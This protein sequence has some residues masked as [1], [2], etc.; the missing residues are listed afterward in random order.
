MIQ[1]RGL[2]GSV[3]K[4]DTEQRGVQLQTVSAQKK[5]AFEFLHF[6]QPFS[7]T[8]AKNLPTISALADGAKGLQINW[9]NGDREIVL[10]NGNGAR[11]ASDSKRLI[12]REDSKGN[13]KRLIF[14]LSS[15]AKLD[16]KILFH[17]SKPVS[18]SFQI[19]ESGL[20]R[21]KAENS[22][23]TEIKLV[24]PISPKSIKVN[25]KAVNFKFEQTSKTL[26]FKLPAGKNLIDSE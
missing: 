19:T 1:A 26:S 14:Q 25:G 18:G 8:E 6:L 4:G 2:P 15:E 21:G 5:T 23:S 3:A 17:S 10:L 20:L 9:S 16:G 24:I 7:L 22:E 11:I 13:W 12:F